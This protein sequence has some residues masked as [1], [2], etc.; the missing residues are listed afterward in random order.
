MILSTR[1]EVP[2]ILEYLNDTFDRLKSLDYFI[3]DMFDTE[4]L[5][6]TLEKDLPNSSF[7]THKG[8][9][10]KDILYLGE[11]FF[12]LTKS[13]KMRIQIEI[14]KTNMCPLFHV[15]HIR[16]RL[17]CTYMGPGTEWLDHSNVYRDGLGKG[18]NHKIVKDFKMVNK[19]RTFET[20][21][22]KGV[23]YAGK[24]LAVVHRSPPIEKDFKTRVLLKIDECS[25]V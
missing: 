22:L 5:F 6:E 17:L 3:N 19:A 18:C 2:E 24:D 13:K 23:M 16:Q 10:I 11:S 14:V 9:F 7:N 12:E 4:E 20:L 25:S 8:F 21:I 1:K 15:D